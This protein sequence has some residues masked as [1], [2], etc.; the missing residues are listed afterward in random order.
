MIKVVNQQPT[1]VTE[2]TVAVRVR[3]GRG[4]ILND[5]F[6]F[7]SAFGG[8]IVVI[9]VRW[10]IPVFFPLLLPQTDRML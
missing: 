9:T 3:G 2:A 4:K 5:V 8:K 1:S 10:V 6:P 7:L